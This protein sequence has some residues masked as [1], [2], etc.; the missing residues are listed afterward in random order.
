MQKRLLKRGQDLKTS[1]KWP[2]TTMD[3]LLVS[4]LGS[5]EKSSE[6][7]QKNS[8]I[9]SIRD[10]VSPIKEFSNT[11][12]R[13]QKAKNIGKSSSNLRQFWLQ[14][15]VTL[16]LILSSETTWTLRTLSFRPVNKDQITLSCKFYTR[17]HC[18]ENVTLT[19]TL[20][21]ETFPQ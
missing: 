21:F 18:Y 15:Y 17:V 8:P 20:S 19:F 1:E 12:K 2:P 10:V 5:S 7:A 3:T 6:E 14:L 4:F 16:A 9:R 13:L 11:K